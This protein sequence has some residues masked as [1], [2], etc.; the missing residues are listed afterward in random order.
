MGLNWK[1]EGPNFSEG[2]TQAGPALNK[3]SSRVT[4]QPLV[5]TDRL[6]P[7]ALLPSCQNEGA[8]TMPHTTS[9]LATLS[10]PPRMSYHHQMLAH[11]ACAV[12]T[13]FSGW[14]L[15]EGCQQGARGLHTLG[16]QSRVSHVA[17]FCPCQML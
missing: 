5:S 14:D 16:Y 15:K 1:L 12:S 6:C 13:R 2:R 17:C 11:I 7:H 3:W 10:V 8:F 4:P 9:S